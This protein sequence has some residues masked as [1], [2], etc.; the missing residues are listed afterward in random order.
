ME[1]RLHGGPRGAG[2]ERKR[3]ARVGIGLF[4][5]GEIAKT[6]NSCG[7][8]QLPLPPS[9]SLRPNPRTGYNGAIM[10]RAVSLSLYLSSETSNALPRTLEQG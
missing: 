3:E 4:R 1:S 7:S 9:S 10:S 6:A 8:P 5:T 2:E